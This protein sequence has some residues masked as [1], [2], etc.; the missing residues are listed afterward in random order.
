MQ[1]DP[2]ETISDNDLHDDSSEVATTISGY[3]AK[4]TLKRHKCKFCEKKLIVHYQDLQSDQHLNLLSRGGLSVPPKE[5]AG[6]ACSCFTIS[7][8]FEGDI[9]SIRQVTRSELYVLKNYGSKYEFCCQYHLHWRV[10]FASKIV[11]IY[12]NNKQKQTKD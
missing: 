11:T 5:L 10:K 9:L 6:F 4:N 3:I 2:I 12:F 1:R 8:F 7:D